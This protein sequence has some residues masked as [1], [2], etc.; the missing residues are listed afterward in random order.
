MKKIFTSVSILGFFFANCQNIV[1]QDAAFKTMLA[2]SNPNNYTAKDLSGNFFKIDSNNDGEISLSEASFVSYLNVEF[3]GVTSVEGIRSF[4]NL[5][6]LNIYS[7]DITTVDLHQMPMLQYY[8]HIGNVLQ[9][10]NLQGN[11]GLLE[12]RIE[13]SFHLNTIDFSTCTALEK[14]NFDYT[15]LT[16]LNLA[17]HPALKEINC[18][19]NYD[20]TSVQ[21]LGCN[22]LEKLQISGSAL[23]TI[24]LIGLHNLTWVDLHNNYFTTLNFEDQ[25][26]LDYLNIWGNTDLTSLYIKNGATENLQFYLTPNLQYI[27]CDPNQI[28]T[29][30]NTLVSDP[31]GGY[32]LS[33]VVNSACDD[34]LDV[35]NNH[36]IVDSA[37]IY[38]NPIVDIFNISTKNKIQS[39]EIF[40][41]SGRLVFSTFSPSKS[42]NIQHLKSGQYL[43]IIKS[44]NKKIS[45]KILKK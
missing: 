32:N 27:C 8:T 16:S 11:T 13:D 30:Q 24:D 12:I 28:S 6:S 42:I 44:D 9:D 45:R 7:N 34:V 17:N 10:I 1:F 25:N 22:N 4:T 23:S 5:S 40:D 29:I 3:G 20:L 18:Y 39:V 38:P 36:S 35:S 31:S 15:T 26:Q 21:V 2:A 43:A 37:T 19:M 33:C 14:V 41:A